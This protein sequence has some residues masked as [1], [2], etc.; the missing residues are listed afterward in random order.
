MIAPGFV[1]SARHEELEWRVYCGDE[2]RSDRRKA[3]ARA[4]TAGKCS[5][6]DQESPVHR[7]DPGIFRRPHEIFGLD[8]RLRVPNSPKRRYSAGSTIMFSKVELRSP[9]R[10]T[11]AIGA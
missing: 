2:Q 8:T 3:Q 10:I 11:T 6:D 1:A 4:A 9:A 7:C 5:R